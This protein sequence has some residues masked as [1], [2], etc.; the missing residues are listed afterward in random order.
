MDAE[1]AQIAHLAKQLVGGK[2]LRRLPGVD[3]RIDL[4]VDETG[5]GIAQ[6]FMFGGELHG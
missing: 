2:L 3:V 6:G 5:D 4:L 1:Q